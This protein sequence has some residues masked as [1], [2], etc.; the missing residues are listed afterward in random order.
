MRSAPNISLILDETSPVF[1]SYHCQGTWEGLT[2]GSVFTRK[3]TGH[4][5]PGETPCLLPCA[6]K[7]CFA[8]PN[9]LLCSRC[10]CPALG[11]LQH[12]CFDSIFAQFCS[13]AATCAHQFVLCS[14]KCIEAFLH[15]LALQLCLSS[16][17]QHWIDVGEGLLHK[18]HARCLIPSLTSMTPQSLELSSMC[19]LNRPV[20]TL[21]HCLQMV[22]ECTKT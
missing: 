18:V 11:A 19:I 4:G 13:F 22:M 14:T 21:R 9:T 8:A 2:L 17:L 3:K 5:E 20:Y 1:L 16:A 10:T 7:G 6:T 15:I 12:P